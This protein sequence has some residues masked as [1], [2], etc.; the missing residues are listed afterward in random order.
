MNDDRVAAVEALLKDAEAAHAV[1]ERDDLGGVY[2][3]AWAAWYAQYAVE[4]GLGAV[5]GRAVSADEV[6]EFFT[7][8][9]DEVRQSGSKPAE[10]WSAWMARRIVAER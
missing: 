3:E 10:P 4:H 5:L 7:R 6:G 2:D 8:T 1:Y 9:W